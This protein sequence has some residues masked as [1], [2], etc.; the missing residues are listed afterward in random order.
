MLVYEFRKLL[1]RF[2]G[3]NR[4]KRQ[5][6]DHRSLFPSPSRITSRLLR[7]LE[8]VARRIVASHCDYGP[9]SEIGAG[10]SRGPENEVSRWRRPNSDIYSQNH[11]FG[12]VYDMI[13]INFLAWR[14]RSNYKFGMF[15]QQCHPSV[16]SGG[17]YI[18]P[19]NASRIHTCHLFTS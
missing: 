5:R 6:C 18:P 11:N 4:R 3:E 14:Q 2:D 13:Y 16:A 9:G 19:R 12:I 1:L 17:A 7:R 10:W 15:C 8:C